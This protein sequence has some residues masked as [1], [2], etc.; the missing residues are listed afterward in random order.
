MN[1]VVPISMG[2]GPALG[3]FLVASTSYQLLFTVSAICGV[4]SLIFASKLKKKPQYTTNPHNIT[5]LF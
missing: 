1:L 5:A 4:L 2:L 3:G